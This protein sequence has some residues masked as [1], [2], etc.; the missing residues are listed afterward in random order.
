MRQ[1]ALIKITML[2]DPSEVWQHTNQFDKS[3]ADYLASIGF[4]AQEVQVTGG[5]PGEKM[6]LVRKKEMIDTVVS[7]DVG[8][9]AALNKAMSKA[10]RK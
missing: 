3:F 2:F 4:E 5:S 6:L 1:Y 8:P 7:Q 9:K 10:R